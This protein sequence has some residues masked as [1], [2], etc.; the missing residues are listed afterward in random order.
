AQNCRGKNFERPRWPPKSYRRGA[1]LETGAVRGLAHP[2]SGSRLG[3]RYLSYLRARKGVADD[4][5][6]NDVT[7][8]R[9]E[10]NNRVRKICVPCVWHRV[11]SRRL[12]G[13]DYGRCARDGAGIP[14]QCAT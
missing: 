12:V 14:L 3:V 1:R 2:A 9:Y 11:A 13:L 6:I 7:V 4:A 5:T 8:A 10:D